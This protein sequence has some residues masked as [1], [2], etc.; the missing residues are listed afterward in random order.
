LAVVIAP[1]PRG[2]R[3]VASSEAGIRAVGCMG[4]AAGVEPAKRRLAP[5]ACGSA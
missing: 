1:S 4:A 5:R 3:C 2:S